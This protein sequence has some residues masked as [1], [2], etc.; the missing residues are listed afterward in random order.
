MI[1]PKKPA[2]YASECCARTRL[3]FAASLL[4]RRAQENDSGLV[5]EHREKTIAVLLVMQRQH[6]GLAI[7]RREQ[8]EAVAWDYFGARRNLQIL[9]Q[10]AVVEFSP[11]SKA[12]VTDI[13]AVPHFGCIDGPNEVYGFP[14][15]FLA[16]RYLILG[17]PYRKCYP[18]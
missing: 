17:C 18:A 4:W 5:T 2:K 1:G 15:F 14:A 9:D 16:G 11:R 10:S 7:R 13:H 8:I 3:R 6:Q 12:A